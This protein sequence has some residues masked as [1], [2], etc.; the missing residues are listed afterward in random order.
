M[1]KNLFARID[2][3]LFDEMIEAIA[4]HERQHEIEITQASYVEKAIRDLNRK[5]KEGKK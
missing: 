3:E 5:T 1:K 2:A 4:E